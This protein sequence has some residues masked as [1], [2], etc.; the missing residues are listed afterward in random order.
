MKP[1]CKVGSKQESFFCKLHRQQTIDRLIPSFLL[2]LLFLYPPSEI[3]L[4]NSS[5]KIPAWLSLCPSTATC[6]PTQSSGIFLQ[7]IGQNSNTFCSQYLTPHSANLSKDKST[8]THTKQNKTS[9]RV[10]WLTQLQTQIPCAYCTMDLLRKHRTQTVVNK[11][12]QLLR[13]WVEFFC[14]FVMPWSSK[15]D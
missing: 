11:F 5:I 10:A 8:I 6:N 1:L 12:V 13:N 4:R 9:V 7:E 3:A 15:D 14:K 2:G